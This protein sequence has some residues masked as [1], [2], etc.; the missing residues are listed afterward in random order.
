MKN[1][2]DRDS[3]RPFVD[4][5]D[6][7]LGYFVHFH[8]S[9]SRQGSRQ[10]CSWLSVPGRSHPVPDDAGEQCDPPS[11]AGA[12]GEHALVPGMLS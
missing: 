1:F 6:S 7:N 5:L 4:G 11:P 2:R 10:G 12:G 3:A 9:G 8:R